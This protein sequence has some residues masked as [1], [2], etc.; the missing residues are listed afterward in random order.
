M[1]A[2]GDQHF[3]VNKPAKL[4]DGR[5]IIPI[6]WLTN[7]AD[8]I[9]CADMWAVHIDENSS[10]TIDNTLVPASKLKFNMLDLQD[11]NAILSW[12]A[13][14]IAAGH[15]QQMLNPDRALVDGDELYTSFIDVF[16]DDMSGNQSKSWNK[17]W[18]IYITHRN[19]PQRMLQQ[20]YNVH[21]VSTS[22]HASV[23]PS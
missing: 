15:P 23:I 12:S 6:R 5:C 1:Y 13:Q 19:L 20:Q 2:N 11:N 7:E 21:F 17:H 18:N 4:K 9:V 3:Y 22:Q 8:N 14:T 16:G 10:A